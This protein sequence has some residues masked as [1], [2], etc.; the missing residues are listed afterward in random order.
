[1]CCQGLGTVAT[2]YEY[3]FSRCILMDADRQGWIIE[4]T[5]LL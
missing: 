2:A 3:K 4:I 5:K 1:M